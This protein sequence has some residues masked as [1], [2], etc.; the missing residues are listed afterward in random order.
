MQTMRSERSLEPKGVAL[1]SKVAVVLGGGRGI[2]R[3]TAHRLASEGASVIVAA[4]T[5]SE[6]DNVVAE[7][8]SKG[9]SAVGRTIDTTKVK[10]LRSFADEIAGEFGRVD[11]LVNSA[12][13]SLIAPLESTTE[14]DWDHIIDTNLKGPYLCTRAMLDL[15]RASDGGQIVNI[16]SK[17]GLT[18]HRM[19]SAY[20]ASK[21]G[22][23][24]F[25]RALAQ[26]LREE[27]IRVFVIC[28]GP[29]DTPMRWE[30]TPNMDP[31]LAIPADTVAETILF[32]I[33]LDSQTA[34]NEVV[35]EAI[36]Y[37]EQAVPIGK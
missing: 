33:T 5:T 11:I 15:L 35:L 27:G 13:A 2:G 31:K 16:A 36:A 34:M 18:G 7:I 24:G 28:P 30:A 19:V 22:L 8:G 1:E 21:A 12:G 26:E 14:N 25:S 20:S 3:A 37:D 32:L 6:L 23:I 4:R 29:V 9:G 10:D 17:V